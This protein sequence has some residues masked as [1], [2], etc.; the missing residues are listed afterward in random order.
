M[1]DGACY[2]RGMKQR[3]SPISRLELGLQGMSAA[4]RVALW[5][6]TMRAGGDVEVIDEESFVGA[7]ETRTLGDLR[8][9]R[10]RSG[11][12][13]FLRGKDRTQNVPVEH[14]M[15]NVVTSGRVHGRIGRRNISLSAGGVIFSRLSN[16]MDLIV[17][18]AT[19]LAL[20]IPLNLLTGSF[21]WS[22]RF[23]GC[24]FDAGTTQ[25][26]M[27][28]GLLSSLGQ[29]GETLETTEIAC[30][31][32]ASI[33]MIASG[34]GQALP[35]P[36]K[37]KKNVTDLQAAIRRYIADNLSEPDLG[38]ERLCRAFGLSRAQLY[39]SMKGTS[40]IAKTIR[41]LRL[42]AIRRDILSG[43]HLGKTI[44]AIARR[45]GLTDER[46]FRRAFV[47][48]F[49]YPPSQLRD[50]GSTLAGRIGE[51]T[52]LGFDLEQ[53]MLGAHL[54]AEI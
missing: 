41:R 44:P 40:D 24:V 54:K 36:G 37:P 32:Q 45:W 22:P 18:D 20:I 51:G 8:W 17:E 28:A 48:E 1:P 15:V 5:K 31:A 42:F 11:T 13:R 2:K 34:L 7:F 19:W 43:E 29:I 38:Q 23:D 50:W 30:L 33:A 47:T 6:D 53:W 21:N 12:F 3:R 10:T 25:A 9:T 27:M 35:L 14:V 16:P 46:N 4:E 49:G 39:R 52:C 26:A